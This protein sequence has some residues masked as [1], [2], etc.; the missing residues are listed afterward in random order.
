MKDPMVR[1][2]IRLR[3]AAQRMKKVLF[4]KQLDIKIRCE[5]LNFDEEEEETI[6]IEAEEEKEHPMQQ[7]RQ[8]EQEYQ[9]KHEQQNDNLVQELIKEQAA[10]EA[11]KEDKIRNPGKYLKKKKNSA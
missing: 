7:F 3:A 6:T 4:E 8:M 5:F 9:T 10:Q 2:Y 1:E 11:L